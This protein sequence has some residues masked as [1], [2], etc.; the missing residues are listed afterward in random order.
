MNEHLKREIQ[1][2]RYHLISAVKA[3]MQNELE[4]QIQASAE[5]VSSLIHYIE[6]KG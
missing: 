6:L 2:Y 3:G 4:R 5:S 1:F